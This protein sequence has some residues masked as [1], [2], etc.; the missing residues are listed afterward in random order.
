MLGVTYGTLSRMEHGRLPVK[1][2]LLLLARLLAAHAL[3]QGATGV[4]CPVPDFPPELLDPARLMPPVPPP[5]PASQ[6]ITL[7]PGANCG[8]KSERCRPPWWHFAA[9]LDAQHHLAGE[10]CEHHLWILYRGIITKLRTQAAQPT[11]TRGRPKKVV[12]PRRGRP[13]KKTIG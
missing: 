1:P 12:P 7:T 6:G 13:W 8:W 5:S 11:P 10:A 3:A 4:P 9:R 2:A